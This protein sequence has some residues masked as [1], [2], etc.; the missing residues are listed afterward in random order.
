MS[1]LLFS[2]ME[3]E[4]DVPA[5]D[6]VRRG[7]S[8]DALK[9]WPGQE[10]EEAGMGEV[11]SSP[12]PPDAASEQQLVRAAISRGQQ[13]GSALTDLVFFRRHPRRRGRRLQRGEPGFETLRREWLTIRDRV[14]APVLGIDGLRSLFDRAAR[15]Y[16]ARQFAR[17]LV[18]FEQ[19]RHYPGVEPRMANA[20]RSSVLFNLAATNS[21]L[22]RFSTSVI[23]FEHYLAQ[24]GLS[25][26]DRA[27]AQR[28]LDR[29]KWRAGIVP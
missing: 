12:A 14:V 19:L 26:R 8:A 13:A 4:R 29:A 18:A 6:W 20:V 9:P 27:E 1:N 15:F 16:Q 25:D 28:L 3:F 24:P 5:R 21:S 2:E 7:E 23:Y 11:G 22:K 17:A 10:R